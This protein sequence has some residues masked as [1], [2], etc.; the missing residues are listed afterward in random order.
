MAP[1]QDGL[2]GRKSNLTNHSNMADSR[3]AR[4]G[5]QSS[6]QNS[7]GDHCF[8]VDCLM[9]AVF[10]FHRFSPNFYVGLERGRTYCRKALL[11][12]QP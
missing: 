7:V 12:P 9:F 10:T 3:M 11:A 6:A 5:P 4:T 2:V 1:D 8:V